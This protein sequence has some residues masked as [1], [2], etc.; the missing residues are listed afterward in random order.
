MNKALKIVIAGVIVSVFQGCVPKDLIERMESFDQ[1][2]ADE[3][4]VTLE[5]DG[6]Y[7]LVYWT[8]RV[9]LS[10]SIG[11]Y[12]IAGF[13]N[14]S[15]SD[16]LSICGVDFRSGSDNPYEPYTLIIRIPPDDFILDTEINLDPDR[17]SLDIVKE[18]YIFN[19]DYQEHC[20]YETAATVTEGHIS[21]SLINTD[22]LKPISGTFDIFGYYTDMEGETRT[23]KIEDG[24]FYVYLQ[25]NGYR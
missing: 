10:T 15:I 13:H 17:Q 25:K 12:T 23:F 22:F 4:T 24:Y 6:S 19:G 21:F 11:G 8:H 9:F 2:M 14:N 20:K 5:F 18:Y 1:Y 16:S 3:E 7:Y